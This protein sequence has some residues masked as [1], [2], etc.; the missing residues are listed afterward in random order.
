MSVSKEDIIVFY[1]GECGFCSAV[2]NFIM[3]RNSNKDIYFA[4]LQSDLGQETL[5][6][7]NMPLDDF[8]TIVCKKG[9]E[10]FKKS[11]AMFMLSEKLDQPWNSLR[12]LGIIPSFISD[13]GYDIIAKLRISLMGKTDRCRLPSPEDRFRFLDQ[14]QPV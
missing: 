9:D 7:L 8:D 3:D 2:V 10:T 1:D 12:F 13:L 5:R 14:G 4:S 6:S 11:G